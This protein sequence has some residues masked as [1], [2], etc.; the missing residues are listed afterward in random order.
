MDIS[1][2]L[3]EYYI[4]LDGIAEMVYAIYSCHQE[5]L[6]VWRGK[7]KALTRLIVGIVADLPP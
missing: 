1:S 7:H 6:I 3:M 5:W 4:P 2:H